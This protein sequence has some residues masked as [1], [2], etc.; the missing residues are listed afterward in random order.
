V[1]DVPQQQSG[2]FLGRARRA[3]GDGRDGR[4]DRQMSETPNGESD[5]VV[6]EDILD[7][8]TGG[9]GIWCD[10]Q[11][12]NDETLFIDKRETEPG[13]IGQ[14]NRY[15]AVQP[16]EVQDFRDLPYRGESFDLV[17]FDPPHVT[18]ENGMESLK[19]HVTKKYGA[20]HAET[21][22]DDLR[23]GFA[24]LFRVL[25]PGGTLVFKFADNAA[26][27]EEVLRLA[28]EPPLF[29]TRTKKTNTENRFF[30]F[31]KSRRDE[32]DR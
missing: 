5:R 18:R 19:G 11:K 8:T 13:S 4:R 12:N 14:P 28:P 15:Y 1:Y 6:S 3:A 31:R 20:L 32:V 22:Q 23:Q 29:G 7:A 21:W 26:D 25:R 30:V 10:E 24:E 9:K 2:V 16:D 17:V 27:F